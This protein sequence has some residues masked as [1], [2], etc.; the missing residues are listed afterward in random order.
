MAAN[1][2]FNSQKNT[3]SFYSLKEVAWH[4]LGQIVAEAKTP[5]EVIRLLWLLC[6]LI[7]FLKELIML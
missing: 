6:M 3:Y 2:E 7:L 1:L 5:E 4:G